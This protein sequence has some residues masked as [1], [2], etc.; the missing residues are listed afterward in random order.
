MLQNRA[1]RPGRGR[2]RIMTWPVLV[3]FV[4]VAVAIAA[5]LLL[6]ATPSRALM[7]RQSGDVAPRPATRPNPVVSLGINLSGVA[8]YNREP[9]F[10]NLL[11]Q[12]EWFSTSGDGWSAMPASA[13]DAQGW[14]RAL[15]P[16][17]SAPRPFFIAR[18][19]GI[20]PVRCTFSGEGRLSA[21]GVAQMIGQGKGTA[22]LRLSPTGAADEGGW[23]QL[24]ETDPAAP[25]RDLDCRELA[26]PQD[27]VFDPAFVAS[28]KGFAALRFMDWQRVNDNP[29]SRWDT[30]TLPTSSTQAGPHGVAIEHMVALAN[31][32][33]ADPWFVMPYAAEA[34]YIRNF[35]RY[36]R[37][38]L[39]PDRTVYVELGNEVW[40]DMFPAAQQ[41]RREG[42]ALGMGGGDPFRAQMARYA[43]KSRDALK[44]WT[45]AY[46][47]RTERLVRVVSTVNAFP[48]S[49]EMVLGDGDTAR[50]V[51][52]LSTAPYIH[53]GT[54]GRGSSPADVDW[55]FA[56]MDKAI[57]E[58][59]DFAQRNRV[60]ADRHGK[61]FIA[62][63]GG[64]HLVMQDLDFA[65]RIQRDPRME[66]VYAR[67]LEEWQSRFGDRMMLY[68]STAPISHY[69]SWG[70][71]EYAGQPIAET[72]KVR[73]VQRFLA[74]L[75]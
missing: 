10:T 55:V 67:Y 65:A 32:V 22:D 38:N 34:E 75:R 30:R 56:Q 8:T 62:Y 2:S 4:A 52:A 66:R 14:I 20:R 19:S 18:G 71:R 16:G 57:R 46:A 35:A 53:L 31:A 37:A 58:T 43:Q 5:L 7:P 40:N 15:A 12:S 74:A 44:L 6:D 25:L 13:M 61:R 64:Q 39:A 1:G 45:E 3:A 28:L 54:G 11:S 23:L 60:I 69:G 73:A 47:D 36:V 41:A 33:G 42:L 72:P 17:Q 21:G 70:L 29:I 49:A 63:E 24:D 50:W 59:M 48:D 9:V 27:V 68:A 26:V 51:D